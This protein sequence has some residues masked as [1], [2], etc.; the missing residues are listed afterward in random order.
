MEK[1][2][3]LYHGSPDRNIEV[4]EPRISK[5]SGEAYGPLV[6]ASPDLAISSAYLADIP[7]RWSSGQFGDV[8]YALITVP[9]DEFIAN[10]KGGCIYVLP[11]ETFEPDRGLG[12]AE[13]ASTVPVKPVE[14]LEFPSALDAMLDHGVQV[15]FVTPEQHAQ[16][17]S[18]PDHGLSTLN[19]MTSENQSRGVN[20]KAL[21]ESE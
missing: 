5:G 12:S 11:T 17:R 13:W 9:R 21:K 8:P 4:F 6:Y 14:K 7:R 2:P 10:D 3:K 16:I 20:P 1:P 18:S 15:Y 19:S